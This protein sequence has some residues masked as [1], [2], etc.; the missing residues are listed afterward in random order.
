M[1]ATCSETRGG[2]ADILLDDQDRHLAF[3]G[4]LHQH[5]F[6]LID[7]D[8]RQPF[9]RLVHDQEARIAEERARDGQHLLLAAGELRA[10]V[11]APLVKPRK[12]LIDAVD[13]P[14]RIRGRRRHQPQMLVDRKARPNAPALRHIADAEP[15]DHVRLEPRC[16][17]A[18]MRM[19]PRARGFQSGDGVAERALAHAVAADH[20]KDAVVELADTP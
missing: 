3:F 7:D 2:D 14:G 15:M 19:L 1:M 4:K 16:L 20:G 10:A 17:A 18:E 12:S 6:D 11:G 5:R 13:R 9:G 8:R